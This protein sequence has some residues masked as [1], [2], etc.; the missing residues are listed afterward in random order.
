MIISTISSRIRNGRM[1]RMTSPIG[2]VEMVAS[3]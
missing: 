3:T 1:P 2:A